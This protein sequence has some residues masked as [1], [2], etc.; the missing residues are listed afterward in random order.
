MEDK[1][2]MKFHPLTEKINQLFIDGQDSPNALDNLIRQWLKEKAEEIQEI[3]KK[4]TNENWEWRAIPK[5]LDLAEE[6]TLE[7]KFREHLTVIVT[8]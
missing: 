2:K 6:Q 7:D 8:R 5:V 3:G 4:V 1:D